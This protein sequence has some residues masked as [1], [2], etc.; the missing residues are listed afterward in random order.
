MDL[1][2][3]IFKRGEE[4]REKGQGRGRMENRGPTS[5]V[6]GRKGREG[7]KEEGRV[8]PQTKPKNETAHA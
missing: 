5:K 1:R 2:G 4:G 7:R 3:P 8:S 6:R